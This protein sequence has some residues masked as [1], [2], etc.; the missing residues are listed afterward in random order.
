MN[1]YFFHLRYAF[2]V[3]F[4]V[5][6]GGRAFPGGDV[7]LCVFVCV[8]VRVRELCA[9]VCVCVRSESEIKN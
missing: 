6:F 3:R 1:I 7:R 2:C 4:C 8:C 5:V 9:F